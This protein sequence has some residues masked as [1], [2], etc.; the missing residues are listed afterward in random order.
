MNGINSI[1]FTSPIS[2]FFFFFF[3][4]ALS[5]NYYG[6]HIPTRIFEEEKNENAKFLYGHEVMK[7]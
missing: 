4:S 7:F 6:L 1:F 2:V 3:F 5:R